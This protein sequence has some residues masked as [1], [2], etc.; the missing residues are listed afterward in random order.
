MAGISSNGLAIE[1]KR[2]RKTFGRTLVL[3]DLDLEVRW[4]QV[5]TLLG[6]NGSGKTTLLKI[7]AA[8]VRPDTGLLRV[9]GLNGT[10]SGRRIREAVGVVLHD[11][12]LYDDLTG[13][14]NLMFFARMFDLDQAQERIDTVTDQMGVATR[15]HQRI[16]TMSHGTRQRLNI[17]RALLHD[18]LILLMDEPENGL[19]QEALTLLDDVVSCH[20]SLGR[21]ALITTHDLDWGVALGDQVAI[22]SRGTVAY[23]ESLNSMGVTT[24]RE[25]YARH[26]GAR[27]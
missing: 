6:P 27:I 8:L 1:V 12:L 9:A 24:V 14:E 13:Y 23:Q 26:T 25:A 4:G 18:P 19:D 20:K 15:L 21:S 22:L 11:T 17:A 3:R 16:S 7:L 2:L 10:R 5:L